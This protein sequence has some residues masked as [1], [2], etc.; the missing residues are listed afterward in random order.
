MVDCARVSVFEHRKRAL[1]RNVLYL[2]R[3][4]A[5]SFLI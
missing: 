1:K 2:L 5:M 3:A 4:G